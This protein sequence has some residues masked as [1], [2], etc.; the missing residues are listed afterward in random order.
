MTDDDAL[1]AKAGAVYIIPLCARAC[2]FVCMHAYECLHASSNTCVC[3]CV[4]G[5]NVLVGSL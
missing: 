1:R 5:R 4:H 2:A 3:V